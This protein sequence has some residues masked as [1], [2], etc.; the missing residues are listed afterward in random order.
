[1]KK[2]P[3]AVATSAVLAGLWGCDDSNSVSANESANAPQSSANED[4]S[5]E[6]V[7]KTYD[8]LW[9]CS[10][11]REG[12]EI[13]V[14]DESEIYK[15][16]DG[17]WVI[18]GT[19]ADKPS[20][21]EKSSSSAVEDGNSFGESVDIIV[22]GDDSSSSTTASSSSAKSSSSSVAYSSSHPGNV[23]TVRC[24]D[25]WCGKTDLEGR[26]ITGIGDETSGWWYFFDDNESPMDGNS[27]IIFPG[28][29]DENIYGNFFGPLTEQ[30]GGI[31][32]SVVIGSRYEYSFAGFGF[33]IV[34]EMRTGGDISDW[35]GV[36]LVYSSTRAF[37]LELVPEN[38]VAVTE[39]NNYYAGVPSASLAVADLPWSKFRQETGWGLKVPVESVLEKT[40][41]VKLVFNS[42]SDIFIHSIGR[43]GTCDGSRTYVPKSSSSS[44]KSS[45]SA[46]SSSSVRSSSSS[47]ARSYKEYKYESAYAVGTVG[48]HPAYKTS[49]LQWDGNDAEGR[50]QT[51]SEEETAGYWY[52][53]NDAIDGGDS[54]VLFPSDVKENAY[55]NFFGPLAESYDGI[56]AKVDIGTAYE[57]AYAGIGFDLYSENKEGV[58][59]SGLGGICLAYFSTATFSIELVPENPLVMT[60]YNNYKANVAKSPARTIVN[61]PW[62]RFKQETG[63]GKTVSQEEALKSISSIYIRFTSPSEFEIFEIGKYGECL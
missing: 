37:K 31:K 8:D 1:M 36:C 15:C 33:N 18:R 6:N 48:S 29:V 22:K 60:E 11:S 7:V 25:L 43:Y 49:K 46:M 10:K 16:V 20:K 12:L 35:E 17:T 45:S 55:G 41:A 30:Y 52:A 44:V 26:V 5:Y 4:T 51:G 53:F 40:A 19:S 24:G 38:E 28:D 14:S 13:F 61:I 9:V 63:W 56:K 58:D 34:D 57:Y 39:Y 62:S 54:K 47:V 59:V 21:D 32:A 2:L 42:S 50:V 23:T 3:L 27:R